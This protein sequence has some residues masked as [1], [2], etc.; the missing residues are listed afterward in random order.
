[1]D[2]VDHGGLYIRGFCYDYQFNSIYGGPRD[3]PELPKIALAVLAKLD[4]GGP[5]SN[6][7]PTR[8]HFLIF[9][10]TKSDSPG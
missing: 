9:L 3:R 4:H 6:C 10:T 7:G 5:H 2:F 1:M 8:H